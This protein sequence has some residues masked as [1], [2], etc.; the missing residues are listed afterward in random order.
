MELKNAIKDGTMQD[1]AVNRRK[2]R[3][4]TTFAANVIEKANAVEAKRMAAEIKKTNA[5]I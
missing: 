4:A 2:A 5:L 3:T 1:S